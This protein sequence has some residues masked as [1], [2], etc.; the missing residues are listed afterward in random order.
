MA[1][2]SLSLNAFSCMDG[3]AGHTGKAYEQAQHD[4]S[5]HQDHTDL[6]SPFCACACCSVPVVVSPVFLVPTPVLIF[7][8]EYNSLPFPSTTDVPFSV[9]QPPQL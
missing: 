1:I 2:M 7:T 3:M 6:C 5:N 9:W 4:D 8:A